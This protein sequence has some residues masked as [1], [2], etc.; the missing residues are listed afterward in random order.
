[1][2]FDLGRRGGRVELGLQG[3]DFRV[4]TVFDFDEAGGA[5]VICRHFRLKCRLAL[6]FCGSIRLVVSNHYCIL[7]QHGLSSNDGW[8]IK[9]RVSEANLRVAYLR[10][11]CTR[12]TMR[13][14][15]LSSHVIC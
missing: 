5:E 12:W 14:E 11:L 1:M 4:N 13:M 2:G 10:Y 15:I 8:N 9:E 3:G 6:G 7:I